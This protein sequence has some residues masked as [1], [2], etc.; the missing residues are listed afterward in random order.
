MTF[1]KS[2]VLMDQSDKAGRLLFRGKSGSPSR[3]GDDFSVRVKKGVYYYYMFDDIL[4][5]RS[6][7]GSTKQHTLRRFVIAPDSDG[8]P[9]RE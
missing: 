9:G 2:D 6:Q 4:F 1:F 7:R 3:E 5:F 8:G